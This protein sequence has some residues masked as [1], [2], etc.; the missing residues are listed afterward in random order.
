MPRVYPNGMGSLILS[1]HT[2]AD[3]FVATEDGGM[4]PAFGWPPEAQTILNELYRDASAVIF[5]RGVYEVVVPFW[6]AVARDGIPEGMPL[7]EVDL[8]FSHILAP[9]P[10]FVVS[11][12]FEPAEPGVEAI[13]KDVVE[14]VAEIVRAADA[15]VLLLA[16][17]ALAG[18]LADAGLIDELFLIVGPIVLGR[19]RPLLDIADPLPTRLLSAEPL[20]PKCT[21]MR[22]AIESEF[23][24]ER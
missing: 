18:E 19:G 14:R 8:E 5:G 1:M 15:A 22:Y 7:V 16:G 11:H 9:I 21:V 2:T 17:G 24:S 20:P 10:K 3:G 12:G 4:W 23:P 6:T 13:R